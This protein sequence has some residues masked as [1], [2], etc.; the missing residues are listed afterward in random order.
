MVMERI[1]GIHISDI[2]ALRREDIDLQ[3]LAERGEEIF[4]TQVFRH[5]FFHADMH[6]GNI[7]VSNEGQYIAVDF[8]IMGTLSPSDQR[9]I[10]ENFVA[11]FRREYRRVAEQNEKKGRV[12]VC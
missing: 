3:L 11:F 10:A 7:F 6:P 5:S 2:A 1:R 9:Y 8:G 12:P 4:F